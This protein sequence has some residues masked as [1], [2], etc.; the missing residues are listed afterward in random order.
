M[1][2]VKFKF[3]KRGLLHHGLHAFL[4]LSREDVSKYLSECKSFQTKV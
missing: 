4:R 3:E 2:F 1:I